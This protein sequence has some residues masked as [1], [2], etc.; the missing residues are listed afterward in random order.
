MS[1][2]TIAT[3]AQRRSANSGW[4]GAPQDDA[5]NSRENLPSM[6]RKL[7]LRIHVVYP[8][9]RS[10]PQGVSVT[11]LSTSGANIAQYFTN[12]EGEV[13]FADLRP[14][15]YIIKVSGP[16]VQDFS[17]N[18]LYLDRFQS[19]R[20][21]WVH[22]QPKETGTSTST[23][24]MIAAADLNIPGNAK[25]EF[26]QANEALAKSDIRKAIEKYQ[27]AIHIYPQYSMAYN[28]LGAAYMHAN[29]EAEAREAF[30]K[31]IEINPRL[32]AANANLA[33]LQIRDKK[34]S[35]AVPLLQ[36]ALASNPD[37]PELLLLMA[38]AQYR[39][40]Q[41]ALAATYAR[42]VHTS[43]H[44]KFPVAHLV[45]GNALEMQ[46]KP[47]EARAE[48][49]LFLKEAPDSDDAELARQGLARLNTSA[50]GDPPA[51]VQH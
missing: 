49:E 19:P 38:N 31:A 10:V 18:P 9:E 4:P 22:V 27:K 32:S 20:Q 8:N 26:D 3:P 30:A 48:Y 37:D 41:F 25:K 11:V 42:K 14:G 29:D 40:G 33:R 47:D 50:Q 23:Q 39:S 5:L 1:L 51:A 28:N 16:D 24:P 13:T 34:Y 46:H 15:S 17:T 45:A 12:S 44:H 21:E 6:E 7:E 43:E 2:F 35:D 36:R